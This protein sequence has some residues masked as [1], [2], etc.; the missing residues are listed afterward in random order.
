MPKAQI[1]SS[2][3][4]SL[5]QRTVQVERMRTE[6]AA[7]VGRTVLQHKEMLKEALARTH[8][9]STRNLD[10]LGKGNENPTLDT[11]VRLAVMLNCTVPDLLQTDATAMFMGQLRRTADEFE[12]GRYDVCEAVMPEVLTSNADQLVEFI[13]RPV[14]GLPWI[15]VEQVEVGRFKWKL[16]LPEHRLTP[17]EFEARVIEQRSS[18]EMRTFTIEGITKDSKTPPRIHKMWAQWQISPVG[19]MFRIN[20]GFVVAIDTGDDP[21][22]KATL[23]EYKNK[24]LDSYMANLATRVRATILEFDYQ[25]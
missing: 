14:L 20:F 13:A 12:T 1:K 17:L 4:S 7:A 8:L 10:K 16:T 6:L 2:L 21:A 25:L 19:N 15:T 23:E 18:G 22:F 11:L 24:K 5:E 9:M 3:E